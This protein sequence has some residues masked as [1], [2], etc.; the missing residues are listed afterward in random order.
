[1]KYS[2]SH[3]LFKIARFS[4]VFVSFAYFTYLQGAEGL[5]QSGRGDG[6]DDDRFSIPTQRV[7]KDTSQL[8]VSVVGE[9]PEDRMHIANYIIMI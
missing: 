6:A 1:M 7:L 4:F 8:A 3:H 2:V 9:T 5:I